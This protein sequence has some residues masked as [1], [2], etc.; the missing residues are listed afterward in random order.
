MILCLM[1]RLEGGGGSKA[2]VQLLPETA[3][4]GDTSAWPRGGR[5]RFLFPQLLVFRKIIPEGSGGQRRAGEWNHTAIN[6][7]P[8]PVGTGMEPGFPAP[9]H[10]E[11][12][13][14]QLESL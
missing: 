4:K 6:V 1:S 13:G 9:P 7:H 5:I 8:H 2:H 14:E 12:A 3:P 11:R 10:Q